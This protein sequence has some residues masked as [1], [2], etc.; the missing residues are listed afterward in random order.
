MFYFCLLFACP[1]V[2]VSSSPYLAL[3]TEVLTLWGPNSRAIDFVS[4]S[5]ALLVAPAGKQKKIK[6]IKSS[7]FFP[8]LLAFALLSCSDTHYRQCDLT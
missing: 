3:Q 2:I 4:I 8:L 6:C 7:H 5:K 1:I